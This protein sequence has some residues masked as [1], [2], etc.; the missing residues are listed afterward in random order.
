ME[1]RSS[2]FLRPTECKSLISRSAL[3][4]C[5]AT[6]QAHHVPSPCLSNATKSSCRNYCALGFCSDLS[7]VAHMDEDFIPGV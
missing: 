1:H 7:E 2:S 5:S 6:Q 4:N 3:P